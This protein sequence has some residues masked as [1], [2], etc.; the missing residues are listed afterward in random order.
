MNKLM[1]KIGMLLLG[2]LVLNNA[3]GAVIHPVA[4]SPQTTGEEF[5]VEIEVKGVSNLFGVSFVLSYDTTHLD[6]VGNVVQGDFLGSDV[7]SYP[8]VD[9]TNGEVAVGISR[10][11]PASGVDGTGVVAKVK[12]KSMADTS[13]GTMVSFTIGDISA[14]DSDGNSIDLTPEQL[15]V[16]IGAPQ[17]PDIAGIIQPAASSPQTPGE[18]FWVEIEVKDLSNLFGVSFI[19]NYDTNYLDVV[20]DV[21]QG[22]FLG[23]DVVFFPNVDETN[24]EVA[25]GISRRAP[26]SGVDGTGIVAK[27]KFKSMADTPAGTTMSFTIRDISANDPDGNSIDLAP[28]QLD[29]QIGTPSAKQYPP[30][31][32]N[33]DGVVNIFDL[34]LVG[35][36]FG[37]DY[38]TE[39]PIATKIGA[40]SGKEANVWIEAQ[41]KVGAEGIRLLVD[42]NV[43]PVSDL[44]GY[45]FD[46]TFDPKVLEVVDIKGGDILS[47][48]GASTYWNVSEIDNRRGRIVD[49]IYVRKATKKGI[50]TGGILA[51]VVFKV[52]DVS[53]SGSTR[54]NLINLMLADVDARM[55]NAVVESALL[56]REELLVPEKTMLL[57]N[58]PNPFNPDTWIPYQLAQDASVAI[59]IYNLKGQLVRT[60][61]LGSQR[62]GCY[63]TKSRAAYWDGKDSFDQKVSSGVYFYTLQAGVFKATRKMLILK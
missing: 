56:K 44:Y 13:A 26:A 14:N 28:E 63:F 21:I 11:A 22:D 25:V 6:V 31:D 57:P 20:G 17:Q 27:V 39:G 24:G 3:Q 29:V 62:T 37:E 49:A 18:E 50:S 43:E 15:D 54:L 2:V 35:S 4:S 51:T 42:I 9:E 45:Q 41:N 48:D 34:V 23:D 30:W 58:Y 32:V 59:K 53:I 55:I 1:M 5:W 61:Y 40:S 19:L 52:K 38:R 16:Q 12:F 33:D 7:V 60:L 10:R 46:L 47:Q 36:H 8:N